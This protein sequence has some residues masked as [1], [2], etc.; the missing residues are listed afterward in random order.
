MADIVII[1]ALLDDKI[2]E[3]LNAVIE[4]FAPTMKYSYWTL[5]RQPYLVQILR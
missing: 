3:L 5:D 1:V 4:W 2:M